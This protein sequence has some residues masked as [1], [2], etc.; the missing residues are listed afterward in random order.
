M[1]QL[2]SPQELDRFWLLTDEEIALCTG[3]YSTNRLAF[4]LQLKYLEHEGRFPRHKGEISAKVIGYVARQLDTTVDSLND[5]DLSGRSSE[6]HRATIRTHLDYAPSS[7]V[8]QDRLNTYLTE[9]VVPHEVSRATI[10]DCAIA[11]YREQ[12]IEPP[13]PSRLDRVI[14]SA[15]NKDEKR[16]IDGIDGALS[17][18]C[19]EALNRLLETG[20]DAPGSKSLFNRLRAAPGRPSLDVVKREVQKLGFIDD[21]GLPNE[22]FASMPRKVLDNYRQ[23]TSTE[24]ASALQQRRAESRNARVAMYCWVRRREVL[25]DMVELLIRIVHRI[26]ARAKKR[27]EREIITDHLKVRGK[28]TLLFNIAEAAVDNMDGTVRDVVVP[29][30]GGE[31]TLFDLVAEKQTVGPGYRRLIHSVVRASYGNHYRRILPLILNTLDFQSNNKRHRPVMEAIELIRRNR[32]ARH[33]YYSLD[34]API[35]GVIKKNM[36]S[37]I[38]ETD[39]HGVKRVNRI[40][41]EIAV[42]EALR[43]QIRCKEIWVTGADKFRNPDEDLPQDFEERRGDYYQRLRLPARYDDYCARMKKKMKKALSELNRTLP[44]NK[45]VRIIDGAKHPI[46][47]TKSDPQP[48]PSNIVRLKT[49]IQGQWTNTGL[50]DVLKEADLRLGFTQCFKG[51]A[52]RQIIGPEELRRRL[53]LCLYGLGTNTGLKCVSDNE[54][55]VT[56]RELRYTRRRY[57]QKA[58]LRDAIAMVA[59]GIFR[60]RL[61][62]VWGEGTTACASD[63]KKYGAY[64][65][66]LMT[67]WHIRYRGPGVMIYWHVEKKSVCIYSQLKRCSS[68]EVAAMI[69]GVLRHCTD[70]EIDRQYVDSHGQSAVGFAFCS[71]LGFD[72]LPRL[73]AINRQKLYVPDAHSGAHYT[74]LTPI[75]ERPINWALIEQQYDEMVKYTTALREGTADAESI[76]RRFTR[77]NAQ[78]PTYKAL[79]E[80]GKAVKTIFLCHYLQSEALRREIHEGLNV[81]ENWNSANA[82]I[83]YGKGGEIASNR[84]EEQELAVLS[85]HLLQICLVYV[86]TLMI[87]T[88]LGRP[89]WADRLMDTDRRAL[90]PLL[91]SHINPYGQIVLNMDKRIAFGG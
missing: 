13:T 73:K 11:W 44:K 45:L 41:Y 83:F 23:R 5:Y 55:G 74:N 40:S 53:L 31:S 24:P 80:L 47:V 88:V 2:W 84:L 32:D 28:T 1:K 72:L 67:E 49:E 75:L 68:S 42:L 25:D 79:I 30:V 87:P 22:P 21:L 71:L 65:Q 56:E 17:D 54:L 62:E 51:T 14:A 59:N 16:L 33:L 3:A 10:R 90:S 77:D 76:M 63:S 78:H 20:T 8:D 85:L 89:D 91:T 6:R 37:I 48:E 70:M 50:I 46:C 36:R 57:L 58:S 26:S 38:V 61:P 4:A 15:V 69:E 27:V 19:R 29:A 64:D 86:N 18:E 34:E 66:N 81:V 7:T 35:E 82:F 9:T 52:D 12:R 39:S 60:T 43:G